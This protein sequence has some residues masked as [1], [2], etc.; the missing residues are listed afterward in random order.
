[1]EGH[2]YIYGI[3]T[4]LQDKESSWG[5]VSLSNVMAQIQALPENTDTLVVHIR[6][7]GGDYNEGFAIY[8]VLK[9]QGKKI[10]TRVEGI[11]ASIATIPAL[12]GEVRS[13]TENSDFLI[14]NPLAG[15]DG[16]AKEFEEKAKLLRALEDDMIK[17]YNTKTGTSESELRTL[18]DDETML[19]AE[20]AKEY[21]FFT[22]VIKTVKAVAL[23]NINKD[24]KKEDFEKKMDGFYDKI[25][26]LFSAPKALV[27]TTADGTSLDFGADV[28]EETEIVVGSTATVDGAKAEGDYIM[29]DGKTL[30][31]ADG[32]VTEIKEPNSDDPDLE[33]L[34]AENETLKKEIDTLKASNLQAESNLNTVKSGVESLKKDLKS[35]KALI[36][37]D[38]KNFN[39][40]PPGGDPDEVKKPFKSIK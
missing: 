23:I 34:K 15:G 28:T 26:N 39:N 22:E 8:D 1:M 32:V 35:Y 18:M 24:M 13:I 4:S 7:E 17:F 33:A 2:I 10:I 20:Q 6:S 3:I 36:V 38:I 27:L 16:N 14:H 9:T 5:T 21:G 11:C 40:D 37:S 30:V 31:F 25:K 12:A 19:T 29:P